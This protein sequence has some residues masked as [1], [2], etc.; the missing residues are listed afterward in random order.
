[1]DA[2]QVKGS[3]NA[4]GTVPVYCEGRVTN[5]RGS[6]IANNLTEWWSIKNGEAG[7]NYGTNVAGHGWSEAYGFV[8]ESKTCFN[9]AD[10]TELLSRPHAF[11]NPSSVTVNAISTTG[12]STSFNSTTKTITTND[13]VTR[14]R[15]KNFIIVGSKIKVSGSTNNNNALTI[16]N[17]SDNGTTGTITVAEDLTQETVAVGVTIA[18]IRKWMTG[19]SYW[20]T[21]SSWNIA[22]TTDAT[23]SLNSGNRCYG[24]VLIGASQVEGQAIFNDEGQP[25]FEAYGNIIVGD[26][27]GNDCSIYL[28]KSNLQAA[29]NSPAFWDSNI[30]VMNGWNGKSY[31]PLRISIGGSGYVPRGG[32]NIYWSPSFN[33]DGEIYSAWFTYLGYGSADTYNAASPEG[34]FSAYFTAVQATGFEIGSVCE[35]PFIDENGQ[36]VL[37]SWSSLTGASGLRKKLKPIVRPCGQTFVSTAAAY[38]LTAGSDD[39]WLAITGTAPTSLTVN[40]PP[41]PDNGDEFALLSSVAVAS[42]ITL[43]PSAKING[44]ITSITANGYAK[45][46]WSGRQ[47]AW[48]RIG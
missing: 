48:L 7:F 12:G 11:Y 6:W 20:N 14:Q 40:F 31:H 30:V 34:A 47:Q 21:A 22:A 35:N 19:M 25:D 29:K 36:A 3:A 46:L 26:T 44:A 15:W 18:G 4:A 39:K 41:N 8:A 10:N 28:N 9:Y 33:K 17:Y 13:A 32:N 38:T 24:N 27:L 23:A 16:A 1:M 5:N 45:W 43:Q 42:G 2:F 37:G